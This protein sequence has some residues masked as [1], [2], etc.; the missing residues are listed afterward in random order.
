MSEQPVGFIGLGVMGA[1]M[2]ERL[3]ESG[4]SVFGYDLDGQKLEMLVARGGTAA[5]SAHEVAA[6]C[7]VVLTS[8]PS[9]NA[10]VALADDVLLLHARPG[11][12]VVDLGTVRCEDVR[13][14]AAAF[15]AKG[16]SFLDVPVSGRP[17]SGDL[18][19]FAAGDR[20]AFERVR[21]VLGGITA[22]ERIVYY[23]P[24]GA[25]QIAKGVNQLAMGL[26]NAALLESVA[27]GVCA[28]LSPEELERGIGGGSGWR[29]MFSDVC[30]KVEAGKADSIGVKAGQ[31]ELFLHEAAARGF[32]LP[33]TEAL[34]E[35]LS[36]AERTVL[37]ANRMSPSYWRELSTR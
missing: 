5:Q 21:P 20:E 17:A 36:G 3:L 23:G 16:G 6:R 37:E 31:Y 19:M 26:V 25:G 10:L 30:R 4:R 2:A 11:F 33:I 18:R 1:A 24:S 29:A 27:F 13:R 14:L 7:D 9:S 8:L 35:Y 28:G 12:V 34:A 15:A 32:R 22:P